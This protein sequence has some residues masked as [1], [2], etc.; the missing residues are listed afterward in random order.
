MT[1]NEF[2]LKVADSLTGCQLV[3]QELK[4]YIA[5]AY[6]AIQKHLAGRVPFKFSSEHCQNHAL[7]RLIDTFKNLTN[8][9]ELVSELRKF[10]GERDFLIH[11][12]ITSCLDHDGNIPAPQNIYSRLSEIRIS[13][14]TIQSKIYAAGVDLEF[15]CVGP[16]LHV[17]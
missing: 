11:R 15:D 12:A 7:G 1:H 5:T 8:D 16:S 17:S 3:E 4:L 6:S 2:Y 14:N 9:N 13:A 10:K